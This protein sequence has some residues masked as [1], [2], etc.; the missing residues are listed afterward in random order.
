MKLIPLEPTAR[1]AAGV[2]LGYSLLNKGKT[3]CISI[4][5]DLVRKMKIT[6]GAP[7][8]L[9]GDLKEGVAQLTIMAS[10]TGKAT[11]R[12]H[13]SASGRGEWNIP[14][15]GVIKEAFA[16]VNGMTPLTDVSTSTDGLMFALPTHTQPT[17]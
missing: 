4:H 14:Y 2:L 7:L 1:S 6:N 11:R 17:A 15:S 13:L 16:V 3:L 12:V 9:D 10:M 8:R 5:P